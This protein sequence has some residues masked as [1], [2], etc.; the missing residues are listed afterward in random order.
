MKTILYSFAIGMFLGLLAA[1]QQLLAN[2][3]TI[4]GVYENCRPVSSTIIV[5]EQIDQADR[6]SAQ[7]EAAGTG[8]SFEQALPRMIPF[9][10]HSG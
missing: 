10:F 8:R 4:I 2:E 1:P 7:A 3:A 5:N 9:P 6:I